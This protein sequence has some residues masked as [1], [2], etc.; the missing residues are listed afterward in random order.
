MRSD[1]LAPDLLNKSLSKIKIKKKAA[2]IEIKLSFS[3]LTN[4]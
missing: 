4:E 1:I 2:A 3:K